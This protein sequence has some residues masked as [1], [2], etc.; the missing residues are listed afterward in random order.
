M[1]LLGPR[2]CPTPPRSPT[3][4]QL[5]ENASHAFLDAVRNSMRQV[6][7]AVGSATINA[8][9]L[10]PP[11][12]INMSG[13]FGERQSSNGLDRHLHKGDRTAHV[14]GRLVNTLGK[15]IFFM[16]HAA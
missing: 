1:R 4:W 5:I 3:V 7:I 9:Y 15:E 10:P 12:A 2:H 8:S 13:I 14:A 16:G 6:R 11:S